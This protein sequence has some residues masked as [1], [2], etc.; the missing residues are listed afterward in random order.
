MDPSEFKKFTE[1]YFTARGS[2]VFFSGVSTD[3]TIEQTLMKSMSIEGSA[4]KRG[5]TESV[6]HKWIKGVIFF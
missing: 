3:Q 1:G 4:F 6:V 2:N 5:V